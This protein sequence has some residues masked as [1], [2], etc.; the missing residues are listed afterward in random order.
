[1]LLLLG[2]PARTVMALMGWSSA[3]MAARY[4]HVTDPI[5]QEVARQ[6]DDLIWQARRRDGG[7]EGQTDREGI[8]PV[9]RDVLAVILQVAERALAEC[10]PVDVAGARQAV[11]HLK[12]ALEA[13][14]RTVAG[15]AHGIGLG[16]NDT[17]LRGT[18]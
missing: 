7:G 4:Q 12:T 10:P 5:R 2:V 6:V 16:A 13:H 3:D 14:A 17:A 15:G 1:M 9:Q 11:E 18:K 8:V